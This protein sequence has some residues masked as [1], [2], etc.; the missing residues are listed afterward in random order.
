[1]LTSIYH[2]TPIT[3]QTTTSKEITTP[4]AR[5]LHATTLLGL[6]KLVCR[7]PV[8]HSQPVRAH[9]PNRVPPAPPCPQA[10]APGATVHSAMRTARAR[11]LQTFVR[12]AACI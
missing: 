9:A 2:A 10:C 4:L 1:M 6:S 7:Q 3:K 8:A 11:A 5:K 12:F